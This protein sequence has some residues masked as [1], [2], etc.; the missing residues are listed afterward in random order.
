[1]LRSPPLVRPLW[2]NVWL[3][4]PCWTRLLELLLAWPDARPS[5]WRCWTMDPHQMMDGFRVVE[6]PNY[7]EQ[8]DEVGLFP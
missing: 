1:M 8:N 7:I 5:A 2:Y 3:W 4:F 6:T